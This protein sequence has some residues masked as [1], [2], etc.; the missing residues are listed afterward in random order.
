MGLF[1]LPGTAD[2]RRARKGMTNIAGQYG[3][4]FQQY[5]QPSLAA[6]WQQA[7]NPQLSPWQQGQMRDFEANSMQ[8]AQNASQMLQKNLAQRGM[9]QSGVTSSALANLWNQYS[10]NM[11]GARQQQMAGLDQQK[12]QA[13]YAMLAQAQGA[14]QGALSANQGVQQNALQQQAQFAKMLGGLLP[15]VNLADLWRMLQEKSIVVS[16]MMQAE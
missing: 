16:G 12:L 14:G 10:K 6:L 2:A 3:T 8:D 7:T 15:G 9:G 13:L 11:A 1:D 4:A 5:Y